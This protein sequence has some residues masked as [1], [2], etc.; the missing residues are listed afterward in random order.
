MPSTSGRSSSSAVPL[1]TAS[2]RSCSSRAC[3]VYSLVGSRIVSTSL[4][5]FAI[6][7]SSGA[8]MSTC[9]TSS[10]WLPTSRPSCGREPSLTEPLPRTQMRAPL[11]RSIFFWLEPRGPMIEPKK[12]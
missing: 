1:S 6:D 11:S 12:L 3:L 8:S 10:S 7:S 4:R 5:A 2:V 9:M